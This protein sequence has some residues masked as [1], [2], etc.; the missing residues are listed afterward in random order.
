MIETRLQT[1]GLTLPAP[2]APAAY[3]VP[4]VVVNNLVFIAGQLPMQNANLQFTGKVNA[5][6]ME[7]GK[8]AAQLCALNI[9]A[10]LQVACNN[11]WSRV[12][13]CVRLGGFVQ[14]DPDF[15]QQSQIING[16]S[17]LL[18]HV[19]GETGRHART[20]V[21]ATA[22]PLN[23]MVEIDAIFNIVY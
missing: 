16:A 14:C 4:F 10:Q 15:H 13:N 12:V 8:Q 7:T 20:A 9:L 5:D 23:A 22:L 19:F 21:G 2:A 1:L 11:D 17:E 18:T 6:N 3:Y